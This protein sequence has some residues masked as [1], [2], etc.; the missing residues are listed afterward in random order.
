MKASERP[1]PL[2]PDDKGCAE[3]DC[4]RDFMEG[5]SSGAA[6][7]HMANLSKAKQQH[8][9]QVV[10]WLA[11]PEGG[12]HQLSVN[13]GPGKALSVHRNAAGGAGGA[14]AAAA[15]AQRRQE[16]SAAAARAAGSTGMVLYLA[17]LRTDNNPSAAQ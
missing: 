16:P 17:G 13:V 5:G 6:V 14:A 15:G 2:C 3:C 10:G 8:V 9:K 7:L 1:L 11:A 12:G 4:L